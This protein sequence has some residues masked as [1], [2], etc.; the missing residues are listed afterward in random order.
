SDVQILV[1]A[2]QPFRRQEFRAVNG[3]LCDSLHCR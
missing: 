1:D 3:G 2:A